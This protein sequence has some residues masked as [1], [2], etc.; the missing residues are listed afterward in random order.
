M[1]S[2]TICEA[3]YYNDLEQFKTLLPSASPKQQRDALMEAASRG[4]NQYISLLL[5]VKSNIKR[6]ALMEAVRMG[7]LSSVPLLLPQIMR[8]SEALCCA[9][10]NNKKD[11]FDFLLPLTPLPSYNFMALRTCLHERHQHFA[12]FETLLEQASLLYPEQLRGDF[13]YVVSQAVVKKDIKALDVLLAHEMFSAPALP[14]IFYAVKNNDA[15]CVQRLL[16]YTSEDRCSA[17]LGQ[18]HCN[19][20]IVKLL[21]EK[22]DARWNNSV[23]L[24]FACVSKQKDIFELLYPLSDPHAALHELQKRYTDIHWRMLEERIQQDLRQALYDQTA[25]EF[26][27]SSKSQ[28]KM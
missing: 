2:N 19:I 15:E 21:L 6:K 13:H 11:V 10:R 27:K 22:A 14:D 18:A 7:Y 4:K 24:G 9:I 20:E 25:P 5:P 23:A 26:K 8:D 1:K 17:A 16:P 12:L 28:R 3:I